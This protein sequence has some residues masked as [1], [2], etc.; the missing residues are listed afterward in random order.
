MKLSEFIKQEGRGS[1]VKLAKDIK[2][3]YPDVS[4]WVSGKRPVP[5]GRCMA[6]ENAT[7]KQVSRKD[8]RPDDYWEIWA[9]LPK[10]E[11]S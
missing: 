11:T 2:A 4:R 3:P 9:D 8:L 10:E 5:V 7:N 1:L 6:I